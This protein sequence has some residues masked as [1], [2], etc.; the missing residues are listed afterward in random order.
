VNTL[1]C[2]EKWRG[3]QR[4]SL[5]GNNFQLLPW[6]QSL[7]LGGKLRMGIRKALRISVYALFPAFG[8]PKTNLEYM[9]K[10]K[11]S[12][13]CRLKLLTGCNPTIPAR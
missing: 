6:D 4:I 12:R 2:L 8:A 5:P 13:S 11:W 9:I 3:K 7:P 10:Q 1:Y